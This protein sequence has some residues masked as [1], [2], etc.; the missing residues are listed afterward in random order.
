MA[1]FFRENILYNSTIS[2]FIL[3]VKFSVAEIVKKFL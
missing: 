3:K 2:N 1:Y